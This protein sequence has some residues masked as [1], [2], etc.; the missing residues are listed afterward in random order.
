MFFKIFELYFSLVFDYY[1]GKGFE[2][3]ITNIVEAA[4]AGKTTP[5]INC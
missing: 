4:H 2:L 3:I 5:T 1:I